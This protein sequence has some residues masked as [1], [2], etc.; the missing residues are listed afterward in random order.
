M[1]EIFANELSFDEESLMDYDNI[2]ELAH[3]R[4]VLKQTGI[5]TC[6]ISNEEIGKLYKVYQRDVKYRNVMDFVFSFFR[7]PY[8]GSHLVEKVSD[9]YILHRWVYRGESCEG[10]AVA[11]LTDT[12]TLS[13]NPK[14]W[15]ET[16]WFLRDEDKISVKNIS[17][18]EHYAIH[19]DWFEGIKPVELKTTSTPP[20][21]KEISL[22]DDH[23]KDRL[24]AFSKKLVRSPY[25]EE[26]LNS[27]P[28]NPN[29]KKFIKDIGND[30]IIECVLFWYDEGFG[31][32]VKTTGRNK[33]ETELI[34]E[35]LEREYGRRH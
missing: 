21:N 18:V 26:I 22:R 23:G 8:A 31:I 33:R 1:K 12:I 5:T 34:A 16:I 9:E 2:H 6:R 29:E 17:S 32:V 13:I 28:F 20:M 24:M 11:F 14:K 7:A 30:G 4:E 10:L 27:L 25:V 19:K 15:G 35:I 3:V